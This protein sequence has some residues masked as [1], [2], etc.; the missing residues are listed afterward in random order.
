M[1]VPLYMHNLI[2]SS[3]DKH[4]KRKNDMPK[5]SKSKLMKRYLR[6]QNLSQKKKNNFL[7]KTLCYTAAPQKLRK[8][9]RHLIF[10][11]LKSEHRVT[12]LTEYNENVHTKASRNL[13]DFELMQILHG[14]LLKHK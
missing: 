13:P 3:P 12:H 6:P 9:F 14:K 2:M 4:I 5:A 11:P 7:V 1:S 8:D 10:T